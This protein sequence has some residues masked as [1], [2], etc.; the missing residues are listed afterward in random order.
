MPARSLVPDWASLPADLLR[1]IA[2][3]LSADVH[4]AGPINLEAAAGL[5][6]ALSP[7]RHWQAVALPAVSGGAAAVLKSARLPALDRGGL[8]SSQTPTLAPQLDCKLRVESYDKLASPLLRR[9]PC[10]ELVL[11][12]LPITTT[13]PP[14]WYMLNDAS[15]D[16]AIKADSV[17]VA[18]NTAAVVSLLADP[19]FQQ[20]SGH[21][22]AA[23]RNLP[24]ASL[25]AVQPSLDDFPD[26]Q[27][28]G[29]QPG[30]MFHV[31]KKKPP[32]CPCK[33]VNI[34][35]RD[36]DL[37]RLP[38]LPSR[39]L[40]SLELFG[41]YRLKLS[42]AVPDASS[43]PICSF[44]ASSSRFV[45]VSL[46]ALLGMSC[47]HLAF[48]A[49]EFALQ[50]PLQY[51]PAGQGLVWPGI[52]SPRAAAAA[53]AAAGSPEY[54][55]LGLC[56]DPSSVLATWL[57]AVGPLFSCP[58]SVLR[59]FRVTAPLMGLPTPDDIAREEDLHTWWPLPPLPWRQAPTLPQQPRRAEAFHAGLAASLVYPLPPSSA[60][61]PA[62]SANASLCC[63]FEIRR[64]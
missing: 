13:P 37:F 38:P 57:L 49:R 44:S 20:C 9:V 28:L 3:L 2:H 1:R 25:A 17:T 12:E 6:L 41:V 61:A 48:D 39:S 62:S 29:L 31:L 34:A 47:E 45:S 55:C 54:D 27:F 42:G 43:T 36:V 10:T 16:A 5:R 64:A 23:L 59:S 21:S 26:L 40:Q 19:A 50:P 63:M 51:R 32:R 11:P 7:C 52:P 4:A 30:S 14:I 18:A 15:E 35:W 58:G 24:C 22:L 46:D 60:A 53:A 33:V 8:I 56:A